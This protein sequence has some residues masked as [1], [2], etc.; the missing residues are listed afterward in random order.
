MWLTFKKP[1]L[2]SYGPQTYSW[3]RFGQLIVSCVVFSNVFSFVRRDYKHI[4][5]NRP[6]PFGTPV[7]LRHHTMFY[8][9]N[10]D[11]IAEPFLSGML[12]T[13][14]TLSRISTCLMSDGDMI[15]STRLYLYW[16]QV[17]CRL[18]MFSTRRLIKG[19][20][21]IQIV[22]CQIPHIYIAN[23]TLK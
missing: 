20:Q 17:S 6:L 22:S 11:Q 16:N 10:H 3:K 4:Y 1:G 18:A 21:Q 14:H 13:P 2:T 9:C 23:E 8:I 7:A 5:N 15:A 19:I 12:P